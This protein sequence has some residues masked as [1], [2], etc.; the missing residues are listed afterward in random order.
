MTLDEIRGRLAAYAP[1]R[2]DDARAARAAVAL[3]LRPAAGDTELLV[4]RRAIRPGDPWSGQVGLPGGRRQAGDVDLLATALR[5]TREEVQIDV[6]AHGEVLGTLDDLYA[7]ARLRPLDLVVRPVVCVLHRPVEPVRDAA[8]VADTAWVPLAPLRSGA[9]RSVYR[10]TL[11]GAEQVYP[12]FRH[13]DYTIWGV[14]YAI[15]QRFFAALDRGPAADR[16]GAI[17]LREAG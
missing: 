13:G 1:S 3:V 11:D 16:L 7:V 9:A 17:T 5:E 10:R 2:V 4:I 12:A 6:P 8:E 14:T 15:L